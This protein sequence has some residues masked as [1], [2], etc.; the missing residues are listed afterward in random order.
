MISK[1][2]NLSP[3]SDIIFQRWG[4]NILQKKLRFVNKICKQKKPNHCSN[5]SLKN[6]KLYF[7]VYILYYLFHYFPIFSLLYNVQKKTCKCIRTLEYFA[8]FLFRELAHFPTLSAF[9]PKRG[10]LIFNLI[11]RSQKWHHKSEAGH[12]SRFKLLL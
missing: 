3:S 6:T 12:F 5:A 8:M 1:V 10:Q 7:W 4:E 9:C 11:T 2:Q